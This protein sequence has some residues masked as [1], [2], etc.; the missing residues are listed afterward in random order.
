M[1]WTFV[2]AYPI[3]ADK[4]PYLLDAVFYET[5]TGEVAIVRRKSDSINKR[6]LS[7]VT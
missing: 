4:L 5:Q 3:E 2:T 7:E 6:D 1:A